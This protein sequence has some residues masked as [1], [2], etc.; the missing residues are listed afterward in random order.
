MAREQRLSF[1]EVA[2]LYDEARPSYP[3]ALVQDVIDLAPPGSPLRALEV[4][5][6]TGK[7]T[8]LFAQRGVSVHAVEP[9]DEMAS[10]AERRLAGFGE[11]TI[12]RSDFEHWDPRGA[13]FALIYAA[14]AWHWVSPDTGYAKAGSLLQPGGLLAA[15]WNRPRWESCA[16]RAEL[17]EAYRRAVPE[18][19]SDDP[20][21]PGSPSDPDVWVQWVQ[22]IGATA[23][24]AGPE[25][26]GYHWAHRYSTSEYLALLRTHSRNI[27][28]EDDR[29][30][31]LLNEVGRVLDEHGGRLELDYVTWLYL[32]RAQ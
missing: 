20:M 15:F 22:A 2:D 19:S 7:A 29:R 4:G 5:A 6:G 9:S 17:V 13:S 24:L 32:A 18:R 12:D 25:V 21:H 28:L 10:I 31:A 27:V 11:I 26:R 30:Q 14:Q 16:L 1:G 3:V 8:R 23:G